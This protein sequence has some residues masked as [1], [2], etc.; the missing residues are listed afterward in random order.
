[1]VFSG[2]KTLKF[3]PL[4]GKNFRVGPRRGQ[5]FGHFGV[6]FANLEGPRRGAAGGGFFFTMYGLMMAY[7]GLWWLMTRA[8]INNN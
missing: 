4:R 3:L 6:F 7:G 5:N 2:Q 8:L 1:M